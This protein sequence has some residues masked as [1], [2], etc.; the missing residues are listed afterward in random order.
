MR[1]DLE[2][3]QDKSLA[4]DIGPPIAALGAAILFGGVVIWLMGKSPALAFEVYFITPLLE[5]WSLQ[6]LAV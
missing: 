6:E 2:P 4:L 3:R 5:G 1:I